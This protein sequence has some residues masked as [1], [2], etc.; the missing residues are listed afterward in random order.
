[1][2]KPNLKHIG[3]FVLVLIYAL[4]LNAQDAIIKRDSS[5]LEVTYFKDNFKDNYAGDDFNYSINDTGGI[6]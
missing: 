1:M 5:A 6:N 3:L 2:T 4:N